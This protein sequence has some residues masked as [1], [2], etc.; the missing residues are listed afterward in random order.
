MSREGGEEWVQLWTVG[1]YHW[2]LKQEVRLAK[3]KEEEDHVVPASL[4]GVMWDP[5]V[6]LKLHLLTG[7]ELHSDTK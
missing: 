3:L 2:Y 1:N 4:V 7:S 5:M 6:P